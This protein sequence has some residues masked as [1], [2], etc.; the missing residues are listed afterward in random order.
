M[1]RGSACMHWL[2]RLGRQMQGQLQ[3][4]EV[5]ASFEH[6]DVYMQW[7]QWEGRE[8]SSRNGGRRARCKCAGC[9]GIGR[10]AG[11]QYAAGAEAGVASAAG[12]ALAVMVGGGK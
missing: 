8:G 7:L 10:G 9:R 4:K 3:G 5:C 12:A 11:E 1:G 2:H 6:R